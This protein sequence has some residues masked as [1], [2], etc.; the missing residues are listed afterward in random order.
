MVARRR[1][2][3]AIRRNP[4]I[5]PVHT[6]RVPLAEA[7]IEKAGPGKAEREVEQMRQEL[8]Q[9]E[10]E[11]RH[12]KPAGGS[13]GTIPAHPGASGLGID[14]PLTSP[15]DDESD[16]ESEPEGVK[17]RGQGSPSPSSPTTRR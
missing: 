2:K 4:A 12:K 11:R 3:R 1:L 17:V 13:F 6:R 7:V 5:P 16:T 14:V 10:D 9:E 15:P 8:A